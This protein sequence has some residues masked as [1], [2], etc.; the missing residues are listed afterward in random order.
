MSTAALE[1][2]RGKG[3]ARGNGSACP[4]A[5]PR[6]QVVRLD[7][8]NDDHAP[9]PRCEAARRGSGAEDL[10]EVSEKHRASA[11]ERGTEERQQKYDGR[12]EQQ[13]RKHSG[14]RHD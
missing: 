4:V 14:I 10:A 7:G 2:A 9:S 5:V 12:H 13:G 1:H 3:H 11:Q 8:G 6:S